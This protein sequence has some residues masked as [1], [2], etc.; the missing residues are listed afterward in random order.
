M[1]EFLRIFSQVAQVKTKF[2]HTRVKITNTINK[3]KILDCVSFLIFVTLF[4][5]KKSLQSYCLWWREAN[6]RQ[7]LITRR[8]ICSHRSLATTVCACTGARARLIAPTHTHNI[9]APKKSYPRGANRRCDQNQ[10][11]EE[12]RSHVRCSIH[13]HTH[14]LTVCVRSEH[15][16]LQ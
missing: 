15:I 12:K 7:T 10:W 6:F 3:Y 4:A 2:S 14:T 8:S 5:Y 13:T 11:N 9:Y 1:R 16:R